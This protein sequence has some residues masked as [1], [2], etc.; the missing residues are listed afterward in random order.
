MTLTR[1]NIVEAVMFHARPRRP[2][3]EHQQRKQHTLSFPRTEST[4]CIIFHQINYIK[5]WE[6]LHQR[7]EF[8]FSVVVPTMAWC[9]GNSSPRR[10]SDA[11]TL[12]FQEKKSIVN[13]ILYFACVQISGAFAVVSIFF[14]GHQANAW[15]RVCVCETGAN[16]K[17]SHSSL[18]LWLFFLLGGFQIIHFAFRSYSTKMQFKIILNHKSL[19]FSRFHSFTRLFSDSAT[20][21]FFLS[22]FLLFV[23][24]S[25]FFVR[26][27]MWN[28]ISRRCE[29]FSP[30]FW[31][32]IIYHMHVPCRF[33]VTHW[34]CVAAYDNSDLSWFDH[35]FPSM[36]NCFSRTITVHLCWIRAE[37]GMHHTHTVRHRSNCDFVWTSVIL[38]AYAL[39]QHDAWRLHQ[40][41]KQMRQFNSNEL[42]SAAGC[43]KINV[44][45]IQIVLQVRCVSSWTERG[46]ALADN[47]L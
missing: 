8:H 24:S 4:L 17:C 25:A 34:R 37:E 18:P 2:F 12:F 21:S 31:S 29:Q 10:I 46:D 14:I 7:L 47:R 40:P 26:I 33:R 5:L 42:G 39:A 11:Q 32:S 44:F 1:F 43:P 3:D 13:K 36:E 22:F 28:V 35:D 6:M 19:P 15:V 30:S 45:N 23:C 9:S 27:Q 38:A 20:F 41:P 16:M